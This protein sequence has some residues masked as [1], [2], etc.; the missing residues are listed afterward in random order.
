MV[1][2]P[3]YVIKHVN[4]PAVKNYEIRRNNAYLVSEL[5]LKRGKSRGLG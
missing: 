5:S 1:T 2:F 3:L 4:D